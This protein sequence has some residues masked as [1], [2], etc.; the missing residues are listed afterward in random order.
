MPEK[1][2]KS[3]E[4]SLSIPPLS[5]HVSPGLSPSILNIY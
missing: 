3:N 4:I 1:T 5:G 2:T